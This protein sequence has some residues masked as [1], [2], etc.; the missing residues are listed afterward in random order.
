[1]CNARIRAILKDTAARAAREN[2]ENVFILIIIAMLR[3]IASFSPKETQQQQQRRHVARECSLRSGAS[4]NDKS[5]IAC[6][7]F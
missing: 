5:L 2:D 7:F 1:M 4:G 6:H 3:D